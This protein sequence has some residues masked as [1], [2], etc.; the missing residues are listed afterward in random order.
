MLPEWSYHPSHLHAAAL[1]A[2]HDFLNA[3]ISPVGDITP[4]GKHPV[5]VIYA[6]LGIAFVVIEFI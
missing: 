3:E 4:V 6:L 2:I 5:L 1:T